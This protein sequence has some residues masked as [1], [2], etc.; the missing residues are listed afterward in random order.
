MKEKIRN[1]K[2]LSMA[3]MNK[4]WKLWKKNKLTLKKKVRLFNA[5]ILPILLYN[6][7]TWSLT[8]TDESALNS[9]HRRLLRRVVGIFW[10]DKIKSE[11][12]Y[13]R[14]ETLELSQTIAYRRH[15][16]LGHILRLNIEAPVQKAMD[17]YY[18][19]KSK[20]LSGRPKTTLPAVLKKDLEARD[21]SLN[22]HEVF[23]G[24]EY[25]RNAAA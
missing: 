5:Y 3:S 10:P 8:K 25:T 17:N 9:F 19:S 21:L 20:P 23:T 6:C 15:T 24:N 12:L 7:G 14:T 16:L 18:M 1:R 11:E 2:A 22:S 4:L 13:K